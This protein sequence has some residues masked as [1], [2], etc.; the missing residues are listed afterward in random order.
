MT[1]YLEQ[2][3]RV[4]VALATGRIPRDLA[5]WVLD[6]LVRRAACE[7]RI[8]LRNALVRQAAALLSGSSWARAEQVNAV[9]QSR[10]RRHSMPSAI[11][12]LL[13]EADAAHPCP[14]STKQLHRIISDIE[15]G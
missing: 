10:Q 1:F 12:S 15:P 14:A 9:L 2:M 11:Q 4:R 7:E 6:E 13:T 3:A 8:A 5:A